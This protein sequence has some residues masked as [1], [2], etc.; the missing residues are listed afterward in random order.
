MKRS[1]NSAI[2]TIVASSV[3]IFSAGAVTSCGGIAKEQV[4][5]DE[6]VVETGTLTL[7]LTAVGASGATYR[8]LGGAFE[9]RNLSTGEFF[10]EFSDSDPFANDIFTT[11]SA[12]DYDV[13]LL[14]GWFMEREQ[15]GIFDIVPAQLISPSILPVFVNANSFSSVNFTFDTAG[16]PVVFGQGDLQISIDVLEGGP[17]GGGASLASVIE[18]SDIALSNITLRETLDAALLNAGRPGIAD[19]AYRSLIDSYA[20]L[21]LGQEPGASH[22]DDQLVA[23]QPSLNGFPL[24]C[25]RDEAQQINN[26][27]NWF[28]IAYVNRLDL[29]PTDGANCGQAR[30]I[31][32]NNS[33]VGNGRMLMIIEATVPNPSPTCG[34]DGCFP[35]A[36][37]WSSLETEPDSFTRGLLLRQAFLDGAI[38]PGVP[39]FINAENLGPN[40]GQIRTNNFNSSPWTLREFQ[41]EA[42]PTATLRPAPT[43]ESPNGEL[44]NDNN[45]DPTAVACRTAFID[46]IPG[47]TTN[48]VAAMSLVVPEI[49]KNSESKNDFFSED[50]RLHLQNGT[51]AYENDLNNALLGT[52]LTAVEYADRARFAGSCIGCH[53]ETAGLP[54]GNGVTAPFQFGFVHVSE[55][56]QEPCDGGSCFR[57]SDALRD[58]FL[59]HR[60]Q[61][62]GDLIANGGICQPNPLSVLSSSLSAPVL[63]L[64][65][66]VASPHGH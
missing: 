33:P 49:C 14:P 37:F 46:A 61:V 32:A 24:D 5:G 45:V 31:F 41:F 35:I 39:A 1:F 15:N 66:Q 50:Y 10:V 43:A 16:G 52:G 3:G 29:A 17:G 40:G 60:Q 11:V 36:D 25:G 21:A 56:I 57:I 9:M 51:G 48:N 7:P 53:E 65:G 47:L 28:P 54:L 64:G 8:L 63:T 6:S 23:G 27:D 19:D 42:G 12:G 59:P 58:D 4:N 30:I 62:L 26:L 55:Q 44:W 34:V 2:A 13:E 18:T 22:C 20:P 38:I